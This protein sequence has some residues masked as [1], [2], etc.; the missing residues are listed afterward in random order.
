MFDSEFQTVLSEG[1]IKR[2]NTPHYTPQ[3]NGVAERALVIL[4]EKTVALLRGVTEGK[5]D[6]LWTEDI[7]Y[8][9]SQRQYLTV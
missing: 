5:S 4:P 1:G 8:L 6:R 2:E 7:G 9:C 3:Y